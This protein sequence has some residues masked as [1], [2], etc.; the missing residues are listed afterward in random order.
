M[1]IITIL[2]VKVF[3]YMQLKE[4]NS[5]I[6]HFPIHYILFQ[7]DALYSLCQY[8]KLEENKDAKTIIW[9]M[10]SSG[11]TI[12]EPTDK[13]MLDIAGFNLNITNVISDFV[14]DKI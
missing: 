3:R 7:K 8:R 13:R 6:F 11:F 10:T 14:T 2:D 12:A 1:N 5:N 4:C 9:A